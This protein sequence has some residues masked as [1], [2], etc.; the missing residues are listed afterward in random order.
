MASSLQDWRTVDCC[1]ASALTSLLYFIATTLVLNVSPVHSRGHLCSSCT[2]YRDF[3]CFFFFLLLLP[4]FS[5]SPI[6]PTSP[7]APF[8]ILLCNEQ[9]SA[10]EWANG[11]KPPQHIL[12]RSSEPL[13]LLQAI[14][15]SHERTRIH[16]LLF[17]LLVT[18]L[19]LFSPLLYSPFLQFLPPSS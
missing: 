11:P 5:T 8:P 7:S 14:R 15:S 13:L 10:S 3:L 4:I 18:T 9:S 2:I 16:S 17:Y 6:L 19:P 12:N 1:Q